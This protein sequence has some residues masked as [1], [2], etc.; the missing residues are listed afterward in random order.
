MLIKAPLSPLKA[1]YTTI[2]PF[3]DNDSAGMLEFGLL[4]SEPGGGFFTDDSSFERVFLLLKGRAELSWG[5]EHK[6][7]ER[8]SMADEFPSVL[9]VPAGLKV[10]IASAGSLSEFAV[11]KVEN[12]AAFDARFF[13]KE[14]IKVQ[15][16]SAGKVKDE[17]VRELRTV[18]DDT[19]FPYSQ[20][21]MGELLNYPGKWSSYPP[22]HHPHPEIYHYRFEPENG[23]GYAEEGGSV[24]KV[25]QRDTLLVA[26][27]LAHPQ[28]SAPGYAMIYV[29][30][31]PH[32]P[33]NRFGADSRKFVPEHE[34][35]L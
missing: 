24:Y 27:N 10:G 22:H 29:W 18:L 21:A 9:H 8:R 15:R 20:M 14:D 3:R 2:V 25:R 31:M 35:V 11:V 28:T 23:F 19:S 1:G 12:K 7:A 26:P 13:S 32:L 16:L 33:G 4:V 5:T 6:T 34:W 30:A 17:T